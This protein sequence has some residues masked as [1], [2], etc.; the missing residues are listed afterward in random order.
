M[1]RCIENGCETVLHDVPRW[2][3]GMDVIAAKANEVDEQEGA[4][5]LQAEFA[6]A[7]EVEPNGIEDGQGNPAQ[8]EESGENV[9]NGPMVNAEIFT[10]GEPCAVGDD[11]EELLLKGIDAFG[12]DVVE[13][14]VGVVAH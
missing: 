7:G 2:G 8:V 10:G 9:G 6:M 11:A 3:S 12:V 5:E 13:Q 4:G 14:V 1:A